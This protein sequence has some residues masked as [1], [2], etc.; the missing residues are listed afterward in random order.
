[1]KRL[2]L[3][4]ATVIALTAPA[5][6]FACDGQDQS[7]ENSVKTIT[8]KELAS[9]THTKKATAVDANGNELR[10]KEGVIPGAVLLTSVAKF[11]PSKELPT[12]K[13]SKLVFYCANTQCSASHMAAEKAMQAGYTDVSVLPDGI[14]GWKAQGQKTERPAFPR[15]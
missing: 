3:S 6:T 15:S 10:T 5:V 8:V 12:A 4:L 14:M 7:A 11:D 1:M 13:D 2:A 9:L